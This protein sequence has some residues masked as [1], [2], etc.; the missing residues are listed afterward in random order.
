MASEEHQVNE[1]MRIMPRPPIRLAVLFGVSGA[2]KGYVV[3][4]VK[5]QVAG[6]HV[7]VGDHIHADVAKIVAPSVPFDEIWSWDKGEHFASMPNA[8]QA[9]AR[10]IRSRFPI[11]SD[12]RQ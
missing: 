1:H 6:V 5:Q 9:F 10:A 12:C 7:I 11:P 8:S 3:D 4:T 2:G